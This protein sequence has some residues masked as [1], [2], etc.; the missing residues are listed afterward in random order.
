MQNGYFIKESCR[1]SNCCNYLVCCS[2]LLGHWYYSILYIGEEFASM[3]YRRDGTLIPQASVFVAPDGHCLHENPQTQVR[4]YGLC[5]VGRIQAYSLMA[6]GM[7]HL[8]PKPYRS[9]PILYC[10]KS[11]PSTALSLRFV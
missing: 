11:L 1:I 3:E 6:V 10:M 9:A 5:L 4:C 2:P 7:D 8:T